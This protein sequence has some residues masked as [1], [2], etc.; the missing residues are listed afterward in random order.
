MACVLHSPYT[1]QHQTGM[2]LETAGNLPWLRTRAPHLAC[3]HQVGLQGLSV[4]RGTS[5]Q[6]PSRC[7]RCGYE[8]W[9]FEPMSILWEPPVKQ[10]LNTREHKIGHKRAGSLDEQGAMENGEG[11]RYRTHRVVHEFSFDGVQCAIV[12]H[13]GVSVAYKVERHF[14]KVGLSARHL[15][16]W[17]KPV[18]VATWPEVSKPP[19]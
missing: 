13:D 19:V 5:L 14:L 16:C 10:P 7:C 6:M 17:A 18:L 4:D 12:P 3:R 9:G 15:L 2:G 1:N 8:V 11:H